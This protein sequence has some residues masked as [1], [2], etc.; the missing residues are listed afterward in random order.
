MMY[1][2]RMQIDVWVW[3]GI[4]GRDSMIL[5]VSGTKRE[6]QELLD[7]LSRD[8]ISV[9]DDN[10]SDFDDDTNK[11]HNFKLLAKVDMG[12]DPN[13]QQIIRKRIEVSFDYFR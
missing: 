2:C 11:L 6:G 9:L 7:L 3:A 10:K 13:R 1:S 8:V 5:D 4:D 12:T